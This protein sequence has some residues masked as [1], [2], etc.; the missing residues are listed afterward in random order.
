MSMVSVS[1]RDEQE[2]LAR[3]LVTA[4]WVKY[5]F[6]QFSMATI[7]RHLANV[8]VVYIAGSDQLFYDRK[9]VKAHFE[10]NRKTVFE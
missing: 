7:Y 2:I 3:D 10:K 8:P 9:Q 6:P 5:N 1:G 4:K